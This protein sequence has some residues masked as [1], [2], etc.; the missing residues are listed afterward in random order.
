MIPFGMEP[1]AFLGHIEQLFPKAFQVRSPSDFV[2]LGSPEDEIA[3][4]EVFGHELP[5]I[6]GQLGESFGMN[7][8]FIALASAS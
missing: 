6:E 1:Y 3:E 5:Q 8:R 4:T 2:A 7:E